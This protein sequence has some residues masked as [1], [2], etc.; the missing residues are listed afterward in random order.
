M[1]T[2]N[3]LLKQ[4]IIMTERLTLRPLRM[5]DASRIKELVGNVN[6]SKTTKNIPFP[7]EDGMAES[8]INSTKLMAAS[9]KSLTYAIE[10][11]KEELLVGSIGLNE[12]DSS[13]AILGHRIGSG[14]G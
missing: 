12:I 13:E 1:D 4:N 9:G 5:S 6:V 11:T 2:S 14:Y 7:Y 10:F 3:L 8:W